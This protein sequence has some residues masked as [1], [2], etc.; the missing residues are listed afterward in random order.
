MDRL[1]KIAELSDGWLGA[2][3]TAPDS[4]ALKWLRTHPALVTE[5]PNQIS[6]LPLSDGAIALQWTVGEDEF[7]AEIRGDR[8]LHLIADRVSQDDFEEQTI[9][10]AGNPLSSFIA[11]G[12]VA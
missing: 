9:A 1:T 10:L 11:T 8:T 5:S 6:V 12:R 3:S 4:F 2:G 7:I